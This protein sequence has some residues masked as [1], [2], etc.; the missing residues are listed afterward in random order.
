MG[1]REAPAASS[2]VPSRSSSPLARVAM[3]IPRAPSGAVPPRLL[4]LVLLLAPAIAWAHERWVPNQPRFPINRA[5]FQSMSGEV[6]VYSL[7]A[8][9]AIFGVVVLWYLFAPGLV[10]ALT[11][12]TLAAQAREARRP[13]L[14]RA[15][16]RTVRFLLDG[17]AEGAFMK[18]G[19]VV[20]TFVFSRVPVFVLGL[21]ALQGWLVMPSYPLP[22]SELGTVLRVVEV[23]LAVWVASGLFYPLLGGLMLLVYVYLC[24]GYGIA[25]ID[26]IPVL[27]SAFF[28]LFHEQ[29]GEVNEKQ[30]IGMRLSLGVGFF[31]LGLINKIYLAELFIGVGD[32][33]PALLIGPQ[34]LFPGLTRE[35]WSFTTALGE[36]VFG[37]LLL[38]GVFNRIS[39]MILSFVFGNFILVFGAAEVVHVYPIAGFVLLFFRGSIGTSLDGLVFRA[40]VRLWSLL[41]GRSARLLYRSAVTL[42]AG[43]AA[44]TLMFLPLLLITEVVPALDG[45][46]VSARYHAPPPAPPASSW[47]PVD[48]PTI[49]LVGA[50][51]PHADHQPRHGGVVTMSGDLHVELVVAPSGGVFVYLS[52]AVRTPIAPAEASGSIEIERPGEKT[53]LPLRPEPSG[54]LAVAGPPPTK[55]ASY[56]Y[57]LNVRGNSLDLSLAVPAG[58]TT[59][60]PSAAGGGK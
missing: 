44:S 46:A 50:P 25:G 16:R 30:L 58:G 22:D 49:P 53:T 8:S 57:R 12:V 27:A 47:P 43:L 18:R 19:L 2:R 60:L 39:T 1:W 7:G 52:D 10:D 5:F 11:P 31:L 6:L 26:A 28:Y 59:A 3:Q 20:A 40:N 55:P 9:L 14:S 15:A 23:I 33:H 48:E 38:F 37:L 24:A 45:T 34:S 21:G 35:A 42:V 4:L 56:R 17:P 36:M 32:Q 51:T 13:F 29:S 41:R 54:S